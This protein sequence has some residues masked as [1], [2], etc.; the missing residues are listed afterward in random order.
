MLI[1]SFY[2]LNT[3]FGWNDI[4][5]IRAKYA[6][7]GSSGLILYESVGAGL[8]VSPKYLCFINWHSLEGAAKHLPKQKVSPFLPGSAMP[9]VSDVEP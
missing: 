3:Y 4:Q 7:L 1:I 6:A 5:L 2:S 8:M 9:L